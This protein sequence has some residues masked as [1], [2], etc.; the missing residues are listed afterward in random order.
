MV[1][2]PI[3]NAYTNTEL[4]WMFE[5]N[6]AKWVI[7]SSMQFSKQ[8]ERGE[9]VEII[10]SLVGENMFPCMSHVLIFVNISVYRGPCYTKQYILNPRILGLNSSGSPSKKKI[11]CWKKYLIFLRI[12][13]KLRIV[14]IIRQKLSQNILISMKWPGLN[15]VFGQFLR[16][17]DLLR[18]AAYLIW[19]CF[20]SFADMSDRRHSKFAL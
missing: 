10:K 9:K 11:A 2:S 8:R 16:A 17:E 6:N 5:M 15:M 18:I 7:S 14:V 1:V 12:S 20:H 4:A 13:D 19:N 3:N